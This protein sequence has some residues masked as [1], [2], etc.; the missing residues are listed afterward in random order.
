MRRLLLAIPFALVLPAAARPDEASDLR[1]RVLKAA[2]KEP[3][4][5]QKF[6]LFTLRARGTSRVGGVD[7]VPTAFEVVAVYPGKLKATWEVGEGA[8]KQVVTRCAS[9]DRGWTRGNTFPSADLPAEELNDLRNDA[10]AV[11]ASTLVTLTEKETT[12]SLGERSKVGPDAVVALKLTR[13][14][15][16]EVTLCFDEKTHLLRKMSY[17]SRQNG[18]ML[19]KEMVYGGHK[20]VGGLTLPTTQTTYV[21]RVAREEVYK[22]DEM[23]F[24]FPDKLDGKTFDK[25]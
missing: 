11:F 7:P 17:R 9:D 6:K 25:P 13:R 18:V 16:P 8:N 14:P 4:D 19:L 24:E 10:Y 22:W 15:Y 1:D 23:T 5:I 3:A 21:T 2:A 12:V 20:Q